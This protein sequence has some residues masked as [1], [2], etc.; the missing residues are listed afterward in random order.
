MTVTMMDGGVPPA[1]LRLWDMP[2]LTVRKAVP[3]TDT[4]YPWSALAF[5]PDGSLLAGVHDAGGMR[6]RGTAGDSDPAVLWDP[7]TGD[8]RQSL[9]GGFAGPQAV[10]FAPRAG[11]SPWATANT[12]DVYDAADV[13]A[14]AE[15]R[16]Q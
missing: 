13:H 7:K 3:G 10:A 12:F 6:L 11:G 1:D 16:A 5:S 15:R 4:R 8:V 14:A 2:A 9:D